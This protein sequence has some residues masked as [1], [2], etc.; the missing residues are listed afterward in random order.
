MTEPLGYDRDYLYERRLQEQQPAQNHFQGEDA[1]RRLSDA[2]KPVQEAPNRNPLTYAM[3]FD[4]VLHHH[5]TGDGPG[6]LTEP[7]LPGIQLAKR[8]KAAGHKLVILTARPPDQHDTIQGWLK[9]HGVKADE[10]TNVKPPAEMYIDDR[11][12]HWPRNAGAGQIEED[13]SGTRW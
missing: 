2:I 1:I 10:V 9:G 12:E 3:D 13:G 11:A 8:I 6:R 7:L 4:G 5:H